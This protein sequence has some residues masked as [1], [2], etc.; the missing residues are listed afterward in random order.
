MADCNNCSSYLSSEDI[1]RRSVKCSGGSVA[2]IGSNVNQNKPEIANINTSAVTDIGFT[3]AANIVTHGL[4]TTVVIEYGLTTEYG[5]I[6][7]VVTGSP[8]S[9]DGA[10]SSNLTGLDQNSTYHFR[11][12]AVNSD[13]IKYSNDNIQTT[14]NIRFLIPVIGRTGITPSSGSLQ[15]T[16]SSN[17]TPTTTGG[18]TISTTRS[19]DYDNTLHTITV[20]CANDS[21]GTIIFPDRSKVVS[22]GNHRGIYAPNIGV[23]SGN[24]TTSPLLNFDIDDI[25][26]SVQKILIQQ[27]TLIT[28]NGT[29]DLWSELTYI[30][31]DN[32]G[33]TWS[34]ASNLSGQ[35]NRISFKSSNL[36]YTGLG[37][38]SASNVVVFE[39]LK[40]RLTKMSS[41]DMVIMLTQLTN[42]TGTLP[43]TIVINDYAD[44][45]SP[46]IAVT[47]AVAALKA[48]KSIT[49]I[50][51]GA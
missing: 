25:P 7:S 48:A 47:N 28:I 41:A 15:I 3:I 23:Y 13:G 37:I 29:I 10:I 45:A 17:V 21:S 42:R 30:V 19:A 32:D 31:L 38:N 18:V 40:Y 51:L 46:P 6:Q 35:L 36:N 16:C 49:T 12:K 43:E 8:L 11:I 34:N 24:N 4:E 20:N 44:Y 39:L 50:N 22:L 33:V 9:V 2:F 27:N 26:Q 5:Y 14:T 1:I